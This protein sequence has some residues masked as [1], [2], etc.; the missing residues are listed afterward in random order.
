M[1]DADVD[2]VARLLARMCEQHDLVGARAAHPDGGLVLTRALHHDFQRLAEE[3]LVDGEA[4]L[5]LHGHERIEALLLDGLLDLVLH[6]RR[7]CAR[8]PRVDEGIGRVVADLAQEGE[9]LLEVLIRLAGEADDEIR[10]QAH[11]G[12]GRADAAHEVTVRLHRVDAVHRLEDA[13]AAV[14]DRQVDV[15]AEV[16][17]VA[18]GRDDPVREVLRV[19]GHEAHAAD[20]RHLVDHLEEV[21]KVRELVVLA[22]GVDVLAEQSDFLIAVLHGLLDLADDVLGQAAALAAA[23]VRHDAVGAEVVAAVHDR[24][25]GREAARARDGHVIRQFRLAELHVDDVAV[26][27]LDLL[28]DMRELVDLVGAEHEIDVRRTLDERIALFLRHAARDAEDQLRVLALEALDLTD[29]AVD[30]VLRRLSHT[31]GVDEDEVRL[32]HRLRP[33]IAD[34]AEL[35]HHALRIALV[36]L[37]SV[38]YHF[39]E[40]VNFSIDNLHI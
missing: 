10:R 16:L 30:A 38:Y 5:V 19:R 7:R 14:L 27:R 12:D 20:A 9:H 25:P 11:V 40:T 31:A 32:L 24:H 22:V 29:L 8:P 21:R 36:H 17:A 4:D 15:L 33:L 26:L 39:N 28:H 1:R 3:L 23:H 35:P 6:R 2:E 13:V 37:A 34:C 18:D